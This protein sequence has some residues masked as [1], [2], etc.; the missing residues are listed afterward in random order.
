MLPWLEKVRSLIGG[1][2]GSL[3]YQADTDS[4]SVESLPFRVTSTLGIPAGT[5]A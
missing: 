4:V 5:A 2:V 1:D 3:G